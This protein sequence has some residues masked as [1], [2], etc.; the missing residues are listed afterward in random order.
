MTNPSKSAYE[1]EIYTMSLPARLALV[2]LRIYRAIVS[3]LIMGLYGP[4][5]RFQ[6]SCS[7]YALQAITAYGVMRGGSMAARRLARC[8]PLGGHGHDPVPARAQAG[9]E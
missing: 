9:H 7:E 6:P 2:M 8:H 1:A 4:A 3:P 5:C